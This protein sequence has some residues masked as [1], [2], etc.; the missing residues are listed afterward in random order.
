MATPGKTS[1]SLVPTLP[2]GNARPDAPRPVRAGAVERNCVGRRPLATHCLA[3]PFLATEGHCH[4]FLGP[5]SHFVDNESAEGG[6][7]RR[8]PFTKTWRAA[9]PMTNGPNGGGR[10]H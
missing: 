7:P 10:G 8:H 1:F 6:L 2:R 3:L 4:F 9:A 5:K